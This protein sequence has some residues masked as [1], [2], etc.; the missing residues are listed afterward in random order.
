MMGAVA[1]C[2]TYSQQV[3][4]QFAGADYSAGYICSVQN[5]ALYGVL[6]RP[7]LSSCSGSEQLVMGAFNQSKSSCIG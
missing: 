3:E 5:G 1:T 6:D 4:Q 2:D 7:P